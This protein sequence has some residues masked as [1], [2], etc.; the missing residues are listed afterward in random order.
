LDSKDNRIV[1][2]DT[3]LPYPCRVAR[4]LSPPCKMRWT[5]MNY[6]AAARTVRKTTA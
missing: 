4:A 3:A 1:W 6:I 2:W 5:T